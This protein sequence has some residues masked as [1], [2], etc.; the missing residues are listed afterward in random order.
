LRKFWR[1]AHDNDNNFDIEQCEPN[2]EE[3]KALHKCIKKVTEDIERHSFNTVVSTLMIA[4]NELNDLKSKNKTIISQLVV[5]IS[6]YAPHFAEEL[7]QKLGNTDSVTLAQW[8]QLDEKHLQEDAFTYPVSF[9]GK[10]RFTMDLSAD[11]S[12]DDIEKAVLSFEKTIQY[13][14]GKSPKRVIIVP[15]KI[16]NIVV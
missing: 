16:V 12:K 4:V 9:N 10:M 14:E 8:P 5:L 15:K 2:K 7:W 1:L 3:L 11:L 13:L 6:P